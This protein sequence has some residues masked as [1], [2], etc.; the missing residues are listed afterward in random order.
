HQPLAA[1]APGQVR[2]DEI[3]VQAL[4][5]RGSGV[6]IDISD[7]DAAAIARETFGAG[8]PDAARGAGNQGHLCKLSL[9]ESGMSTTFLN[10]GRSQRR[11]NHAL[12]FGCAGRSIGR[13][14]HSC[15][16]QPSGMSP[17][18][19]ALPARYG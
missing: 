9:H 10:A 12:R 17:M 3:A 14:I 19:K 11:S 4:C 1:L 7:D 6:L 2:L 15:T 16:W 5:V 8:E 13:R 18:V